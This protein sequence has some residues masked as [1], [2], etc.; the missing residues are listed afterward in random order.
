MELKQ[1]VGH[2]GTSAENIAKIKK[3]NFNSSN[4]GWLGKGIYFFEEDK[5][6]A[7]RWARYKFPNKRIDVIECLIKVDV[8]KILD[9]SNPKTEHNKKI[10]QFRIEFLKK[11]KSVNRNLSD[12][13]IDCKIINMVATLDKFEVVRNYTYTYTEEDREV[14]KTI[15]NRPIGSNVPNGIELCVRNLECINHKK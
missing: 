13:E 9:I 1:F 7:R 4:W 10:Q 12:E 3:Y 2:H 6:M 11:A 14:G 5:E 15:G 8:E